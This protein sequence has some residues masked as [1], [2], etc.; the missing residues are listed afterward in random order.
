MDLKMFALVSRIG[1]L[2]PL[3]AAGYGLSSL[4]LLYSVEKSGVD[5][6]AGN[7]TPQPAQAVFVAS[8]ASS[9]SPLFFFRCSR[10]ESAMLYSSLSK[11]ISLSL[12]SD[13]G[14]K[15]AM[16]YTL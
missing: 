7:N 8:F 1:V 5:P 15:G 9:L 3:P 4:L 2:Q 13:D 16:S 14:T 10:I 11:R 12:L 6:W